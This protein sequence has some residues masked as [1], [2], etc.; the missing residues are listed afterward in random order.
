MYL[1]TDCKLPRL[2]SFDLNLHYMLSTLEPNLHLR[3]SKIQL[4]LICL[5]MYLSMAGYINQR[6]I[7][8]RE[9]S[10]RESISSYCLF[11][12]YSL[13]PSCVNRIH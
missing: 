3:L 4:G 8:D 5:N 7:K 13:L 6:G 12:T 10:N 9:F 11:A 2:N 1:G